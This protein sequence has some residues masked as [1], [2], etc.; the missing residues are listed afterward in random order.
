MIMFFVQLHGG[1]KNNK[2]VNIL[3][4]CSFIYTPE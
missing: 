2:M 4:N 1:V 3:S